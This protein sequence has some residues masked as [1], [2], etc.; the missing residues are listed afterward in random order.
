VTIAERPG[1]RNLRG[2]Q[3]WDFLTG[4]QPLTFDAIAPAGPSFTVDGAAIDPAVFGLARYGDPIAPAGPI[5][6]A[7]AL[8]VPAV[9]RARDIVCG[10]LGGIPL[11]VVN[12]SHEITDSPLLDQPERDV[13]RSVTMTRLYEDLMFSQT[14]WW[15][16][17]ETD[18]RNFPTSVERIAPDRVD[19]KDGAVW[20]DGRRSTSRLIRFDS[21]NQGLLIAGARAIRTLLRL[22]AAAANTADDPMPQGYFAPVEDADP[23]EDDEIAELLASWKTARQNGATGYVPAALKYEG[24]QFSPKDLQMIEARQHAVLEIARLTGIDS[25]DLSVS[26]TSR[27]YFNA[28]DRRLE[29][30]AD[31][32]GPYSLAVTD[33]LRMKDVT[34]RGYEVR[35]DFAGFLRA[36]DATRLGNYQLGLTLGLYTLAD[37]AEREGLPTPAARPAA[38]AAPT[39]P[40]LTAVPD[41]QEQ[42][43]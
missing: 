40:A 33:R 41:Q 19:V 42:T 3:L 35:A 6:L 14:A 28:Q 27:T 31:V 12:S 37:I 7:S 24:V 1:P 23:L 9:K 17:T 2:A 11:Q 18:Y 38:P 22:E 29:R 8:Q 32:L 16:V 20:I 34:P 10:S 21:P 30:I 15:K 36:D 25:E 5:S 26:T 39:R 4:R 43:A 13:P